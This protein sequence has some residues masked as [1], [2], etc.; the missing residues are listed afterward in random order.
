MCR[1]NCLITFAWIVFSNGKESGKHSF[2]LAR[3]KK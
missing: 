2:D 3:Q 1:E